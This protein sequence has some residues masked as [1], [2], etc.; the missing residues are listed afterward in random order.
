MQRRSNPLAA[1]LLAIALTAVLWL[2]IPGLELAELATRDL[3]VHSL[4]DVAPRDLGIRL[5][6]VDD[7]SLRWGEDEEGL[8]WPW[9]REIYGALI[10]FCRDAGAKTLIFEVDFSKP[11]EIE[12]T[13][14]RLADAL[15]KTGS[16]PVVLSVKLSPEGGEH[17]FPLGIRESAFEVDVAARRSEREEVLAR[18]AI[19]TA[20]LP[21]TQLAAEASALG[22][23]TAEDDPDG[24]VRRIKPFF[25]FD[26][27]DLPFLGL[28]AEALGRNETPVLT[29]EDRAFRVEY[30]HSGSPA[31]RR[32][33]LPLDEA[34]NLIPRYR[35]P[36]E[37][38][39]GSDLYPAESM[40]DV[41]KWR[42][43]RETGEPP[44][45]DPKAFEDSYVFFG[46][47]AETRPTPVGEL[48]AVEIGALLLDNL[49]NE[50][51]IRPASTTARALLILIPTLA[52]ALATSM[53]RRVWLLGAALAICAVFPWVVGWIAYSRNLWTPIA[54]PLLGVVAAALAAGVLRI[55]ETRRGVR[56]A[57]QPGPR[58]ADGDGTFDVFLSHNSKN[59]PV[60]RELCDALEARGLRVW[61]DER[62][63]VP[64]TAWQD[65]LEAIICTT[66]SAAVL[67]GA[68]GFGPWEIAEMR[69]CLSELVD[70]GSAV[71]PVLLPG[72]PDDVELPLFLRQLTWVDLRR[73]ERFSEEGIDRLVWGVTG[74]KPGA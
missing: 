39:G 49:L 11:H 9:P 16:L 6:L 15:T 4:A 63:I 36:R 17:E 21:V 33:A 60:V 61:L 50:S 23:G 56:L 8:D 35:R 71:I 3:R 73:Q 55:A 70:R 22:H 2:P 48:A 44:P 47:A 52:A 38:G 27:Q 7:E 26:N 20:I 29:V 34:G 65:A 69:A 43:S 45:I 31:S 14:D 62:E 42:R 12:G 53:M 5:I 37:G 40:S 10:E 32:R 1:V 74:K 18:F 30:L 25:R 57:A 13:D 51:F 72:A 66:R 68:D 28:V 67:V 58:T 59:K 46:L 19:D 64:G 24:I 54:A 41:V